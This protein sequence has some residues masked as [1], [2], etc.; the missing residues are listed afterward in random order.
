M[1]MPRP[2]TKTL[3]DP[4]F[5]A[6][7]AAR[8]LD[9]LISPLRPNRHGQI[10]CIGQPRFLTV[11]SAPDTPGLSSIPG[12]QAKRANAENQLRQQHLR[13][14]RLEI[15]LIGGLGRHE[16]P[17]VWTFL[18]SALGKTSTDR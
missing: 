14:G 1:R 2:S 9:L 11:H 5:A 4:A 16:V 18:I 6:S 13:D 12:G 17:R 3:S 15:C 10:D 7:P 8:S